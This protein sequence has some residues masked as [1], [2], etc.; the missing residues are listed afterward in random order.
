M[1]KFIA[2][3]LSEVAFIMPII[4]KIGKMQQLLA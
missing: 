3:S 1:M 4:V 2:L